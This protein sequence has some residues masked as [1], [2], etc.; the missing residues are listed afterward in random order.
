MMKIKFITNKDDLTSSAVREIEITRCH[1][2]LN[3]FEIKTTNISFIEIENAHYSSKLIGFAVVRIK[4]TT[5]PRVNTV[6]IS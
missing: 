1:R 5:T 2:L 4:D 6:L 3:R